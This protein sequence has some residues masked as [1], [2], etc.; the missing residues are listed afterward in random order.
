MGSR[1]IGKAMV[2]NFRV[3]TRHNIGGGGNI[4][5]SA[6]SEALESAGKS[7]RSAGTLEKW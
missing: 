7:A 6:E 2:T 1:N 3:G 5:E 4:G